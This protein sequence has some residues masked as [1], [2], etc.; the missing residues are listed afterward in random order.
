MD[1]YSPLP[2]SYCTVP[3]FDDCRSYSTPVMVSVFA[4]CKFKTCTVSYSE[5]T[6]DCRDDK[7]SAHSTSLAGILRSPRAGR[8]NLHRRCLSQNNCNNSL[9]YRIDFVKNK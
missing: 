7:R 6:C 8:L 5:L 4:L 1:R 9:P 2:Y 3:G